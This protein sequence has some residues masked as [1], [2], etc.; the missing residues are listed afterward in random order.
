M[1]S[2]SPIAESPYYVRWIQPL[3]YFAVFSLSFKKVELAKQMERQLPRLTLQKLR[4]LLS[5]TD[6]S[7]HKSCTRF[8]VFCFLVWIFWLVVC[9]KIA[10]L[11]HVFFVYFVHFVIHF[12]F[13]IKVLYLWMNGINLY[14]STSCTFC[15]QFWDNVELF[16]FL[17]TKCQKNLQSWVP[18]VTDR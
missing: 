11:V 3:K 9:S 16:N 10:E 18:Q 4:F 5:P 6:S 7:F 8:V 13:V 1:P 15:N 12:I 14:N 17:M 2:G